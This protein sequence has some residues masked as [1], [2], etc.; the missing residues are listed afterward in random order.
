[1]PRIVA[2]LLAIAALL[3]A[4]PAASAQGPAAAIGATA[5]TEVMPPPRPGVQRLH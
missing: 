5:R 2:S 3:A 1:M 4:A